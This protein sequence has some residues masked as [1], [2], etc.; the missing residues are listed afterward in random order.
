[1]GWLFFGVE[2]FGLIMIYMLLIISVLCQLNL[3]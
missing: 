1:M 2:R 3:L